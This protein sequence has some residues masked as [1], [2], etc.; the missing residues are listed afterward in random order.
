MSSSCF[1]NISDL[2][3]AV[4]ET[5][6]VNDDFKNPFS[7]VID[8][9]GNSGGTLSGNSYLIPLR[10]ADGMDLGA[11]YKNYIVMVRYKNDTDPIEDINITYV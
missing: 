11:T 7:T 10:F 4:V 1:S 8:L 3:T 5:N 2:V 9:Y 6:I